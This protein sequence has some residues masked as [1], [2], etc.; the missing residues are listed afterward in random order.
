[1]DGSSQQPKGKVRI[2][3]ASRAKEDLYVGLLYVDSALRVRPNLLKPKVV[4]LAAHQDVWAQENAEIELKFDPYIF[5][6][7]WAESTFYL[8]ALY[9][10]SPITV[11][12]FKLKGFKRPEL[13]W[14]GLRSGAVGLDFGQMDEDLPSGTWQTRLYEIR[15]RNPFF[16]PHDHRDGRPS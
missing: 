1:D 3:V 10:S 5:Q 6:F 12:E 15:S 11:D 13:P 2:R 14:D 9:S 16:D 4:H 8:L 7:N